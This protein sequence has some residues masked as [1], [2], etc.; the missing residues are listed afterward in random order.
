MATKLKLSKYPKKPKA[1]AS[2]STL[3]N[4]IERCKAVDKKNA[5]ARKKAASREVLVKRVAK[6]G[7][8]K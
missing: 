3:R 7:K 8:A 6:I 5:E 1:N 4:Y 2:E